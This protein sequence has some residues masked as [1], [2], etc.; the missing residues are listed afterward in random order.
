MWASRSPE[1]FGHIQERL[2]EGEFYL[3]L[4]SPRNCRR[5]FMSFLL[6]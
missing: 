6:R 3:V 4:P 5:V 1:S 2:V